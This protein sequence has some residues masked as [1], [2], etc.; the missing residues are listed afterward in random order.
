M[1]KAPISSTS[2]PSNCSGWQCFYYIERNDSGYEV[3][4][5]GPDPEDAPVELGRYPPSRRP[6]SWARSPPS[7]EE[8]SRP[9]DRVRWGVAGLWQ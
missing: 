6:H 1:G 2:I 8:S 7:M 9:V 5:L 4:F 3:L